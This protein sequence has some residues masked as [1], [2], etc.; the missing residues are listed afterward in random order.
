MKLQSDVLACPRSVRPLV[1]LWSV[2]TVSL[3][4]CGFLSDADQ[5]FY[6]GGGRQP[7]QLEY[8]YVALANE[9]HSVKPCYLIRPHSL[10]KAG[11]N[12]IGSQVSLVRSECFSAV[13][14]SSQNEMVCENVR[15]ASTLFL[16]GAS[17]DSERCRRLARGSGGTAFRLD[18]QELVLLAGYDLEEIDA[19]LVSEGRF[20]GIN[21]AARYRLDRTSTFWNEV[22]MTLLH[23]KQ[24]FLRIGQL[25]G[26]GGPEDQAEMDS[27]E[28]EP[29][30]IRLWPQAERRSSATPQFRMKPSHDGM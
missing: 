16:S 20:S 19:Y 5:K 10:S 22:R 18:V 7:N 17:L 25:P 23:S 21:I 15:S 24:F 14:Q 30:Q 1:A 4:G 2:L 29:R 13:A 9:I 27:I 11:L 12:P 28:W 6:F 26:F 8:Q 3:S